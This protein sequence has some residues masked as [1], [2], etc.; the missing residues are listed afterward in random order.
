MSASNTLELD[1]NGSETMSGDDAL[2][3]ILPEIDSDM[4]QDNY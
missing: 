1:L 3:P 4:F 2:A